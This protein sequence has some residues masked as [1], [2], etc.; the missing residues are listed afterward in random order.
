MLCNTEEEHHEPDRQRERKG[1]PD[2]GN[3]GQTDGRLQAPRMEMMGQ[4]MQAVGGVLYERL[5]KRRRAQA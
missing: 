4:I 3:C 1:K 5:K 2:L